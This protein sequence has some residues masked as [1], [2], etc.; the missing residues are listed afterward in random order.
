MRPLGGERLF[1]TIVN[2]ENFLQP[3]KLHHFTDGCTQ[4]IENE[5]RAHVPRSLEAFD[6]RGDARTV[7][8]EKLAKIQENLGN[9]LHL[10]LAEQ[11]LA[12]FGG[13]REVNVA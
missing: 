6:E 2:L 13:M 12:H 1:F 8:V 9:F 3:G 11:G 7:Y 10:D 4:A 5:A